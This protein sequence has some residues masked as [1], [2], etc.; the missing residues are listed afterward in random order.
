MEAFNLAHSF[1]HI[2]LGCHLGLARRNSQM[3]SLQIR[4]SAGAIGNRIGRPRFAV[5]HRKFAEN[6]ALRQ[7]SE[8]KLFS[9]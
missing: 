8:Q 5:Q 2:A 1:A 3:A 6:L 4:Q 9:V 7:D